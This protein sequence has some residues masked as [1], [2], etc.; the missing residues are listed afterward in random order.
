MVSHQKIGLSLRQA[1]DI[2]Q[3]EVISLVGGGGKTTLMFALAHELEAGGEKVVSTTTT[4][5]FEPSVSETFLIV[6]P[7]ESR[8]PERVFAELKTHRHITLASFKLPGGKLKGISPEMVDRLAELIISPYV[9]VE[10]DGSARKP[11]KAPNATE[12]VTPPS[13]T[14]VIPIVGVDA[15]GCR[16]TQENV[17]RPETI[18]ELTGLPLGGIITADTIATLITHPRGIIKESPIHARIVP[19]IN[20]TDL[21]QDP[22][23]VEELADMI[24]GKG[25]LQIKRVVLGHVGMGT[26]DWGIGIKD[27]KLRGEGRGNA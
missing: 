18:S 10:A 5:I 24:L 26:G 12:P 22:S 19:L 23:A 13:T 6:E 16:L 8:I 9:I 25:H 2:H 4:R 3:G 27:A 17:F 15:L 20:K 1:F 7:D 11:L 14:L 21:A